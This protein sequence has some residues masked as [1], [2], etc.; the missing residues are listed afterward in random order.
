MSD[1]TEGAR[2]DAHAL[3]LAG[4][5]FWRLAVVILELTA[6]TDY[7]QRWRRLLED[8]YPGY[9]RTPGDL[10]SGTVLGFIDGYLTGAVFGWLY[11][12][13]AD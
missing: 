13:F 5:T 6:H 9:D 11:N 7:G 3:G 1:S 10:L 2:I 12:R 4:G 8:I